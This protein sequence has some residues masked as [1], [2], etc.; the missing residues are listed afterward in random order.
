MGPY[1]LSTRLAPGYRVQARYQ[2]TTGLPHGER[3]AE[4]QFVAGP[5]HQGPT[6]ARPLRLVDYGSAA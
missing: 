2:R 4:V 5:G 1:G 3:E 6:K